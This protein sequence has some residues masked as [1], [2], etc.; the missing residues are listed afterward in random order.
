[1]GTDIGH[2]ESCDITLE[3]EGVI[4]D[5]ASKYD[6]EK[7]REILKF[8][9]VNLERFDVKKFQERQEAIKSGKIDFLS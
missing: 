4:I 2:C 9:L 7:I 1:M 3:A 8:A 6:K 5:L